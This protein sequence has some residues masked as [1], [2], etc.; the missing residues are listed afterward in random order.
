MQM[1]DS[2]SVGIPLQVR[3]CQAVQLPGGCTCHVVPVR[4]ILSWAIQISN[5]PSDCVR[6][7]P[8]A[9]INSKQNTQCV[10]MATAV[11]ARDPNAAWWLEATS[12]SS[13][14]FAPQLGR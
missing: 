6:I 14:A 11:T 13:S 10:T 9:S 3:L 2:R 7:V 4:K 12:L 1:H 5:F 8:L